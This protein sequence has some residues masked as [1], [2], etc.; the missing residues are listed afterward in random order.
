[1]NAKAGASILNVGSGRQH[2]V[3]DMATAIKR[4]TGSKS[5]LQW[6]SRVADTRKI[7]K[8]LKWKADYRLDKGLKETADWFRT[9]MGEYG[10]A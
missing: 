10:K 4:T 5:K 3:R 9:H 1:M 8:A 7:R 2:T 6:G